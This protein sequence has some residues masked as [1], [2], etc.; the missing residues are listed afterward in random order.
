MLTHTTAQPIRGQRHDRYE[1]QNMAH[2]A[3]SSITTKRRRQRAPYL[4]PHRRNR[5]VPTPISRPA[6]PPSRGRLNANPTTYCTPAPAKP[7]RTNPATSTTTATAKPQGPPR[8]QP[9]HNHG[10]EAPPTLPSG[11]QSH[12][13]GRRAHFA[14]GSTT[15]STTAKGERQRHARQ[16]ENGRTGEAAASSHRVLPAAPLQRRERRLPPLRE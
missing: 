11:V 16:K 6:A 10:G 1:V 4:Q 8:G 13:I 9:H 5:Q 7:Q 14:T 2:P 12:P 3:A 15:V